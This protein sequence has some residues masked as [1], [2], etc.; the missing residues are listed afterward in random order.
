MAQDL[1]THLK[2]KLMAISTYV[3][4]IDTQLIRVILQQYCHSEC[5]NRD[6]T[7]HVCIVSLFAMQT[8]GSEKGKS[9]SFEK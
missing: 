8:G 7:M 6:K 9:E 3:N 4:L 1:R 2:A 5:K